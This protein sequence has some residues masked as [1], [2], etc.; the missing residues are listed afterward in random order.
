M[1]GMMMRKNATSSENFDK[2]KDPVHSK[3]NSQQND[4]SVQIRIKPRKPDTQDRKK[5]NA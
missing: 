5:H 1:E 3:Q 4:P 2:C